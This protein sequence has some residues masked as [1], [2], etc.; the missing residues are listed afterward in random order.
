MELPQLADGL[1]GEMEVCPGRPG[2]GV[3]AEADHVTA[4]VVP[5]LGCCFEVAVAGFQA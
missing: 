5:L 2:A 3:A 4:F 1:H